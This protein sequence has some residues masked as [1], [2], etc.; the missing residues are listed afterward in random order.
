MDGDR[1]RRRRSGTATD[2]ERPPSDRENDD[3]R[4]DDDGGGGGGG[5]GGGRRRVPMDDRRVRRNAHPR[6]AD[7]LRET[8]GR[9]A[10]RGRDRPVV[11]NGGSRGRHVPRR[12][13]RHAARRLQPVRAD[14]HAVAVGRRPVGRRPRS[15]V[16]A[17]FARRVQRDGRTATH[18]RRPAGL[19][20]AP[21]AVSAQPVRGLPVPEHLRAVPRS[22]IAC[23]YCSRASVLTGGEGGGRTVVHRDRQYAAANPTVVLNVVLAKNKY[24]KL[25]I[26]IFK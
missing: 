17:T 10:H 22:V 11:R 18:A 24:N 5:T 15:R 6:R 8:A 7:P 20:E 1:C 19:P 9:G 25:N 13:V 3:H 23:R 12:A 16:S 21:V 14:A 2:E 26:F 4:E